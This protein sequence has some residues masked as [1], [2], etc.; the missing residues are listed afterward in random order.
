MLTSNWPDGVGLRALHPFERLVS[1]G[2]QLGAK[3]GNSSTVLHLAVIHVSDADL[4]GAIL[5]VDLGF[6][7]LEAKDHRGLTAFA[8]LKMRAG[9]RRDLSGLL[10]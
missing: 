1:F 6:I 7:D 5:E 9:K 4:V 10:S 2:A 8:L 3:T